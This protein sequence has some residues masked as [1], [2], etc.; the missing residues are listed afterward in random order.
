[1]LK[2]EKSKDAIKSFTWA[3]DTEKKH[4]AFYKKA[5]DVLNGGE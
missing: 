3:D 5:L 1:M 4:Q 2:Q